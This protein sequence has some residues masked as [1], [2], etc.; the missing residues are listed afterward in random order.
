MPVNYDQ[1]K[2]QIRKA[3]EKV[4]SQAK[5]RRKQ[6]RDAFEKI[7]LLAGELDLTERLK[8]I[9]CGKTDQRCAIPGTQLINGSF[10]YEIISAESVNILAADGSQIN[11]DRHAEIS[12]G[13]VNTAVFLF[14]SHSSEN[15]RITT[16]TILLNPEDFETREPILNEDQ[17]ALRRDVAERDLLAGEACRINNG[18]PVVALTDG[19]LELFN[20]RQSLK[21]QKPL[22]D[23]YKASLEQLAE[24]GVIAA[25]Y[26]DRPQADLVIRM[27]D[28]LLQMPDKYQP[29]Q[30]SNFPLVCDSDLFSLILKPG[31]RSAIFE[32]YSKSNLE[33]NDRIKLSFFYL[34]TGR[35]NEPVITRVEIPAWVAGDEKAVKLLHACLME[36]N[37]ILDTRPYPYVLHRAH[38]CAVISLQEK[39]RIKNLLIRELT[40]QGEWVSG[41]SNKQTMKD[42]SGKRI[43]I[44]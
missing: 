2:S 27:L 36:Q 39:E 7:G 40:A 25:G 43:V 22:I 38:E 34:N 4:G 3:G 24:A 37:R 28:L 19:P 12:F 11:P 10:P 6:E 5:E 41:K 35:E 1:L 26:I 17:I 29:S 32:L 14:R 15:P 9:L 42:L 30:Y 18:L 44:R 31:E 8:T 13:L 21:G 23:Q 33:M 20:F 16:E